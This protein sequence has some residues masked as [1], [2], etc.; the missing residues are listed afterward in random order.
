[1]NGV[2]PLGFREEL[3][4]GTRGRLRRV[5]GSDDRAHLVDGVL[6]LQRHGQARPAGHE[7]DQL[8]VEGPTPV[9]LVEGSRFW[10]GKPYQPG[11]P[12]QKAGSLEM[13]YDLT[14]LTAS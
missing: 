3:P 2:F 6:P 4:N 14:G 7:L 8:I 12:D 1:M 11:R 13:G 10:A 5:G 9:N